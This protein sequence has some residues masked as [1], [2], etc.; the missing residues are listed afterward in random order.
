[1]TARTGRRTLEEHGMDQ[2]TA[3]GATVDD[4]QT[5]SIGQRIA[6]ARKARGLT[7]EALAQ[8]STVSV[9]LL[10]KVEQGSRDATPAITAAVAKALGVDVTSLTGQ[11]YDQH[12]RR[13]DRIHTLIPA[14]RRALTYWDLPPELPTPPRSWPELKADAE[15][16]A[17]MRQA[18]Q[19]TALAEKLPA[20]LME[21]TAAAHA[22]DGPARERLFELL[23]VLLFAAHSVTYKTG[24]EDL[25]AVVEDRLTWAAGHS[26]DPLMGAL[27]AWARTTSMLHTG[28][29][30]IGLRLLDRV[31]A[32][33][34]PGS[35]KDATSTLR[36]CGPLHLRS[37]ILAA[38][39]GDADTAGGHLAEARSIAEHLGG[40]QDGGWHQ[41]SFGPSNVGIHE[42][43]AAVELGDGTRALARAENVRLPAGLPRIRTGH[44]YVDLSRAQL[45][46]GHYQGALKSLYAARKLAP[47]QTRHHPTT[48]EVLRML[49]RVHRR[50]NEP[51]ARFVGW[52]GGEI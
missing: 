32:E 25:S 16:A 26:S 8:R 48:R 27:A 28:S 12:G 38:R 49:V 42:V 47:Q 10:R 7:Q 36:V 6:E 50:S 21:T 11:P 37:A 22:S 5:R 19:H 23:T 44:H 35:R 43:A 15:A 20:L 52:I 17:R 1:M 18:A 33:I 4:D 31:Q 51:L 46:A 41:L 2:R 9:S 24:Y 40:D 3:D 14:L 30:D 29:Y 39:G 34:D 13:R 45:W